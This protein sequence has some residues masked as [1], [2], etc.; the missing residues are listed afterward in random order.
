MQR[1][2]SEA[3][4][5]ARR[6][7]V[8]AAGLLGLGGLLSPVAQAQKVR[9]RSLSLKRTSGGR[10]VSVECTAT[11][12]ELESIA[13]IR[14]RSTV[15]LSIQASNRAKLP[16]G[17]RL[18]DPAKQTVSVFFE[19]IGYGRDARGN[20]VPAE[21]NRL[22][23]FDFGPA[24]DGWLVVDTPPIIDFRT[25]LPPPGRLAIIDSPAEPSTRTDLSL[26]D[27]TMFSTRSG[28]PDGGIILA[29]DEG[30]ELRVREFSDNA[31]AAYADY[32][33]ARAFGGML[34]EQSELSRECVARLRKG[35]GSVHER[36][37][38]LTT[39]ACDGV[40]LPDNCWELSTLRD[41]RDRVLPRLP[42]GAVDIARYYAIAPEIVGQLKQLPDVRKN[43]LALYWSLVIPCCALI[44]LRAYRLAHYW[45]RRQSNALER[46][47]RA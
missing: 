3:V 43:S 16:N 45:Y 9:E 38:Y 25:G 10:T 1:K 40:G 21:S 4:T 44:K 17:Y 8:A 6:R 39:A 5:N 20:S 35:E 30:K 34:A 12:D 37:C 13:K 36:P 31:A 27:N 22:Q 47:L 2:K 46:R 18:F 32:A 33:L 42:G 19:A 41:F 26:V 28:Q 15:T 14:A 23:D 29:M 24:D 7:F 11:L